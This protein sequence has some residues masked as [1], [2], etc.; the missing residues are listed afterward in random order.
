[1]TETTVVHWQ[2]ERNHVCHSKFEVRINYKVNKH[3]KLKVMVVKVK[4]LLFARAKEIAG[5]QQ[6]TL[7]VPEIIKTSDLLALIINRYSLQPLQ[8]HILLAL[9]QVLCDQ[10]QQLSLQEG[11]EVAV[12]P[13][14]S[15]G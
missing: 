10:E 2:S 14:L 8:N 4:L 6:D 9:N 13:P 1:M 3:T 11:D 7:T 12:I 5:L 15:G